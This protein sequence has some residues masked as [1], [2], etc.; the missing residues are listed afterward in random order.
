MALAAATFCILSWVNPIRAADDPKPLFAS[1]AVL[2]LTLTGPLDRI[3]RNIAAKPVPG[4]LKVGGAAPETLPVNLSVR[5]ITRRRED[6][7]TFP[8]LRVEFT[9]KPGPSSIFK[10]QKRLK[11]VTHCQRSAD[12]QQY[13]LLEY[14]AYRLYRALTPDSFNVRLA[15]IDY[16]RND[17]RGLTTRLG[18][19][20]ED[21]DDVAKRNGQRRLRGVG[22]ISS[23]QLDAAAAAR[24]AVFE[25]MISNLD[26]AMTAG[27]AGEDCCH[28]A[29][30]MAD[31]GATG[32]ATGLIPV[33]YDFDYSGLVNAPYA[34]PPDGI[35][36]VNVQVRR[37]RGFCAHNEDAKAFL[38]QISARRISLMAL[39]DETPGLTDRTRRD[40][41]AYL[42]EFFA[43][44]GSP[45]K[46]A[47]FMKVCLH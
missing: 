3:S 41:A 23:S 13:L 10:G 36:V 34:V 18:F 46:V 43:A 25:Y 20:I 16:A 4:V 7:C 44:A 11:L 12:F 17:G 45:S 35:L 9:Q 40:A 29:R 33:P 15:R 28:N 26:W 24:Y 1:D 2:S 37:Y 22:R 27:P 39:L 47:D 32:V 42:G 6:I 30:L 31:K 5:G 14:T 38:A 8:P 21:V 19:F